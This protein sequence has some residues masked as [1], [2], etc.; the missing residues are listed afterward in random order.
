LGITGDSVFVYE[1]G[2]EKNLKKYDD[3]H[4]IIQD[5]IDGREFNISVLKSENGPEVMPP[6][7]MV[8]HNYEG[9]KPK[10]VDFKAK[11]VAESFE[12]ENT[13]REFPRNKLN[14]VLSEK[15]REI[16]LKCWYV[17][18]LKGYARVDMRIDKNENPFVIEVNA[19]PC[20]S[21]DSGL[22]AA[23]T[24]AGIPIT[25]VLKQIISDLNL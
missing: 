25:E 17:F 6:A 12:Y 19:N 15:I 16:A 1:T 22:V 2:Y 3:S 11:W 13:I 9:D 20:M 10:I 5:Y 24:E 18:G 4:W 21:P 23:T 14:P 8:F 7:E